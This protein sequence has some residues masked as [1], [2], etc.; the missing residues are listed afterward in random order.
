[1][2][3]EVIISVAF[4]AVT[5]TLLVV[6]LLRDRASLSA[7]IQDQSR[8][9]ERLALM[10]SPTSLAEKAVMARTVPKGVVDVAEDDPTV[11]ALEAARGSHPIGL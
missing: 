3:T 11:K 4:M 6:V 7:T 1:M 10:Q 2:S 5:L 8:T 9:I